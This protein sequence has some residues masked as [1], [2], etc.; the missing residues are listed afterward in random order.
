MGCNIG[1]KC[2]HNAR[3]AFC[4]TNGCTSETFR[5][6]SH[7][8]DQQLLQV[9][10]GAVDILTNEK[11]IPPLPVLIPE[12]DNSPT[13]V[14]SVAH[15]YK[16]LLESGNTEF[17]IRWPISELDPISVNY[18]SG[19]TLRPKGVVFNHRGAYLNA[20]ATFMLHEMSSWPIY[21]DRPNVSL[22]GV[23]PGLG[24]ISTWWH[25]TR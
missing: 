5:S 21:L 8:C 11:A 16:S 18:T 25:N 24:S 23:V 17:A 10:Q 22:Q 3:A 1:T 19:T 9:A 13:I 2:I 4:S 20:I 14:N 15:D 6:K 7:L 12:S